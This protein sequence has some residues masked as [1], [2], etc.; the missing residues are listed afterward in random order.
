[1]TKASK[2]RIRK[3]LKKSGPISFGKL[4]GLLRNARGITDLLESMQKDGEVIRTPDNRYQ[5]GAVSTPG[6]GSSGVVTGLASKSSHGWQLQLLAPSDFS[7]IYFSPAKG[8]Q[9]GD[10]VKVRVKGSQPPTAR[11]VVVDVFKAANEVE[12]A[13]QA[14]LRA[15]EVP[16]DEAAFGPKSGISAKT[17]DAESLA[18]RTD[19][20]DVS[21]VT[22]D[23]ETARDFD[24]AVYAEVCEDKSWRLLVAIADVAHYVLDGDQ[25]DAEARRRGNSVYLPDRVVPML[26]FELSNDVCSL[27]PHQDRLAVVCEM[28]IDSTGSIS[29]FKF[30]ESVIRSSAR[31]TYT[32][33][34]EAEK[35]NLSGRSVVINR[36]LRALHKLHRAMAQERQS[37]GALD[38]TSRE[39]FVRVS[40]GVPTEVQVQDRNSAHGL[41]EESM[42]AANVCAARF[43]QQHGL[44]PM[45][46]VHEGPDADSFGDLMRSLNAWGELNH[47][48]RGNDSRSVQSLLE[49]IRSGS[50]VPWVWELQVLRSMKQAVYSFDNSGHFGLALNEYSHFTSPIRR[51]S[52]LYVHRLIKGVLAGKSKDS[53]VPI[54]HKSLGNHLS[55]CERRADDASRRVESW[56][57][58]TLLKTKIGKMFRGFIVGL[59]DFGVFVELDAYF[60]SGLVHVSSLGGD[61]FEYDGDFLRGVSTGKTYQLG[62]VLKVRLVNVNPEEAK[63]DLALADVDEK[64]K[65]IQRVRHRFNR[66]GRKRP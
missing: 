50:K 60:V 12:R 39:S 51:Y 10:I 32:E 47:H 4:V 9:Q 42:I 62:D 61:Y 11:G 26:P 57:K 27:K 63:L 58:C 37:R 5:L 34:A 52:D 15:F 20:R 7:T 59:E 14:M 1:M 33:A 41:I 25:I 29:S 16:Q 30:H 45:Y 19:L 54:Q 40:R 28:L 64:E 18:G 36:S 17:L 24:D 35:G 2:S 23:G 3:I 8:V 48:V 6:S 31:L 43:L 49:R 53:G 22:I 13:A 38:F 46:R 56:L 66:R 55:Q 65:G 44:N 21:F